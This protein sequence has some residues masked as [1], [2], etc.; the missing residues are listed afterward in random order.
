MKIKVFFLIIVLSS[1]VHCFSQKFENLVL[2]P[3]MG[4]NSWNRFQCDGINEVVIKEMADAMVEKGLKDVGYQYIVIDDCWQIGRDKDGYIIVDEEKFPLGIK[5]LADYIHAKGLKF[6]IYSDAGTKTCAGRPGSKGFE[7]KDAETYAKWGVDYLKYDWC[8]T[9][10]QD[11]K[12][13][14]TIMRDALYKSGNPIV[15][16]MCEWGE[17]KPWEWAKDISHLWRT[18]SDIDFHANFDGDIWGNFFGWTK[19]VDLQVGLEKY[20]GPGHWNDP[21]M[22]V[23]GINDMPL[24]EAKAHFSMWCM[25]AAPLMAGNDLRTMTYNTQDILTNPELIAINQDH[26]GKQGFKIEDMG[27]F[28][29]WQKPLANN[30]I[31]ICL[32]NRE[33]KSKKYQLNW[34]KMKIKDFNGSYNVKDLW[35][36]KEIGT[37]NNELS[38]EIPARD[39]IVFKLIKTP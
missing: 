20:A 5:S 11:V 12:Q 24:N 31:A 22:L 13:S 15:F 8:N 21:D 38:I 10:G 3:P 26:L 36:N 29:I 9:Q 7:L 34:S 6:G 28:E 33:T 37:T 14:Y 4:W 18:T 25:M 17:N 23:V 35:K 27:N 1:S 16:S 30:D 39:V 32:F 19:I 2:T